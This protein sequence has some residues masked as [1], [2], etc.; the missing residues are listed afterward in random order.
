MSEIRD[1]IADDLLQDTGA[2]ALEYF[3]VDDARTRRKVRRLVGRVRGIFKT[4]GKIQ[5]SRAGLRADL[6]RRAGGA[7][8][9]E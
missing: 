7:A 3:G 8:K 1:R 2:I 4:G 9:G 6:A 5:G